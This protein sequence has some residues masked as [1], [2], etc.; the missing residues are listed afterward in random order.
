MDTS[1]EPWKMYHGKKDILDPTHSVID[2]VGPFDLYQVAIELPSDEK[3]I[4]MAM[5]M[6]KEIDTATRFSL[7]DGHLQV[8]IEVWDGDFEKK[9]YFAVDL[10]LIQC[11]KLIYSKNFNMGFCPIGCPNVTVAGVTMFRKQDLVDMIK[12]KQEVDTNPKRPKHWKVG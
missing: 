8:E 5:W 2:V 1:Y 3:L 4:Q 9:L 7:T 10:T 11:I 12:I 6:N